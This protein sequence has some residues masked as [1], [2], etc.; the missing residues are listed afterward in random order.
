MAKLSLQDLNVKDKKVLMRVDFN[1][2][3]DENQHI[4]DDTRIKETLPSIQYIL[5]QGGK[6]ILMSHLGRPKG[7]KNLKYS[8][9]PIA[10]NLSELLGKKVQFCGDCIGDEVKNAVDHLKSGECLLLENL[11]FYEAEEKPEKDPFFAKQLSAFGDVFVDD[12]FGNAHRHHSSNVEVPK[13]F[14]NS[15]AAGFL[16]EKE[17]AF[18]GKELSHPKRPF[19]AIIGGAKVSDKLGVIKALLKKVDAIF[20]GGAMAYTFLKAKGFSI[21]SSLCEDDLLEIATFIL[22]E[23]KLQN[24]PI[25]LPIDHLVSSNL[26]GE[27]DV[28]TCSVQEGIKPGFYGVDIGPKTI[29]L[30]SAELLPA[31]TVFWNGPLGIFEVSRFSE[32]TKAIASLVANLDA[33]TIVGGGDSVAALESLNLKDKISHVSTGGG[34]SLEYIEYGTLPGIEV[35]TDK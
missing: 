11:R 22:E 26:K 35:L 13:Y 3:Q 31:K 4:T 6:L 17:I 28:F 7:K 14:R 34:A 24:I 32:G 10:K 5:N 2:P 12:A 18:L 20:I 29:E 30:F 19:Y 8:L 21:G 33:M 23:S 27:S 1:V 25:I 16:M 15:S 9:A